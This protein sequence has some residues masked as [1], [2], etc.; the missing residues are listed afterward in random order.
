MLDKETDVN[1]KERTS[2]SPMATLRH[3]QHLLH[4]QRTINN[5]QAH[6]TCVIVS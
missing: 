1:D 2:A 5:Q 6:V 4:Q 3:R